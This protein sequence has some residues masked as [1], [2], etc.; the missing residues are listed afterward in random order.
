MKI[1]IAGK[2]TGDPNYKEKFNEAEAELKKIIPGSV[3]LNPAILPE[4]LEEE[5]YM[6]ITMEMLLAADAAVFL[7]DSSKSAGA[8]IEFSMCKKIG[9]P[10]STFSVEKTE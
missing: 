4:G 1:Y 6:R 3:I 8:M 5:D 9:K 2:I 10:W 7:P